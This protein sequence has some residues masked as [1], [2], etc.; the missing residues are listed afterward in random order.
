MKQSNARKGSLN[1][2]AN[3]FFLFNTTYILKT[4]NLEFHYEKFQT[5]MR[6]GTSVN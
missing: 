5:K 2:R 1:I 3:T 4:L 6:W